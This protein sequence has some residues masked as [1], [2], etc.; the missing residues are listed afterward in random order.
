MTAQPPP[1]FR[2]LL[3]AGTFVA[4]GF[5]SGLA[6]RM[7]GTVG[8]AAAAVLYA[9]LLHRLPLLLYVALLVVALLVGILV[10]GRAA[11]RLGV[12]DHP[13]IVWD[14]FVGYWIAVLGLP[15]SVPWLLAAFLLFRLLDIVK[16]WPLKRLERIG[17]GAGIMLDDVAAG[18]M[19][20]VLLHG[21]RLAGIG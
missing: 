13:A 2:Q 4:L 19:V 10:C 1:H 14:E 18:L 3:H 17:G 5:G 9:L 16:P 20:C 8:T 11:K 12:A 7:P 15:F 21:A 6:P